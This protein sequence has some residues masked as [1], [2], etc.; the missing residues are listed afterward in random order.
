[1]KFI[2]DYSTIPSVTYTDVCLQWV[3]DTSYSI[4]VVYGD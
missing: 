3:T 1:M 2:I 4:E